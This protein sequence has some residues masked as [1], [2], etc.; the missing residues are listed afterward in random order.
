MFGGED[1]SDR[2]SPGSGIT[3]TST[4]GGSSSLQPGMMPRPAGWWREGGSAAASGGGSGSGARTHNTGTGSGFT[5]DSVPQPRPMPRRSRSTS[6]GSTSST[7][8]LL[9]GQE[10]SFFSVVLG[11]RRALR[12]VNGLEGDSHGGNGGGAGDE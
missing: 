7:E 6:G 1:S 12:V 8:L 5:P 2:P 3:G 9:D 4:S 10:P 11:P